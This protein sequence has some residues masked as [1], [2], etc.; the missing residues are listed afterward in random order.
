MKKTF[1]SLFLS[2]IATLV[3]A[4]IGT[5]TVSS[6]SNQ[7]FWLF[8]DDVLQN[9]YS[10]PS[11][12]I[13]GLQ[14]SSYKIRVEMDNNANNCVGQNV[15]ISNM[16]GHNNF[17]VIRDKYNNYSF[18]KTNVNVNPIYIQNLLLPNYSYFSDYQHYLL[19]GFNPNATYGQGNQHKG[20]PYKGYPQDPYGNGNNYGGNHGHGNPGQGNQGYG[21]PGYGN[22]G[23][24]NQGHGNPGPGNPGQGHGNPNYGS[25]NCMPAGN[26]NLSLSMIEK[27]SFESSK[28][29][30]AKQVA[31]SNPLCVSQIVQ[32][33]RAFSF[34]QSKLDFAK[35][36]YRF[37]VDQNNYLFLNDVFS[38]SASKDELRK[39][40]EGR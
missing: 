8:I 35:Y 7:K 19:P 10:I 9:E 23:P 15:L 34:E 18:G 37:C 38:F 14:F 32:I 22:P 28:L 12:R 31:A 25:P 16:P 26:F 33:C 11:I 29:S 20:N 21:N 17:V 13:S 6:N 5:L 36:A 24:G 27:E 30:T 1:L 3:F 39:F 4:Q 40:I 2:L